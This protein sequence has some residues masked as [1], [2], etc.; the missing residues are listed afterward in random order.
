MKYYCA[1]CWD[2]NP[3]HAPAHSTNQQFNEYEPPAMVHKP[4]MRNARTPWGCLYT[5][6]LDESKDFIVV[7]FASI[8]FLM[9]RVFFS[10]LVQDRIFQNPACPMYR[11]RSVVFRY[12]WF[13]VVFSVSVAILSTLNIDG[14]CR[15]LHSCVL[16]VRIGFNKMAQTSSL[17]WLCCFR[18]LSSV[19]LTVVC[20]F[21]QI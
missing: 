2:M 16:Y 5:I 3:H 7:F 8:L 6:E 12:C 1:T 4:L 20:K 10:S 13:V 17:P 19:S 18:W 11:S 9:S 15:V 14:V 21:R